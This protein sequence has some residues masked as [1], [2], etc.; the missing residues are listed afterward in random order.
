MVTSVNGWNETYVDTLYLD[1]GEAI[2]NDDPVCEY[3][4]NI[5]DTY[6]YDVDYCFEFEESDN[7]IV[8][9]FQDM[10]T[11]GNSYTG[12]NAFHTWI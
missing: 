4:L 3:Y 7:Q 2:V 8:T 1:L 12:W 10:A 11:T 6:I 9:M 5:T